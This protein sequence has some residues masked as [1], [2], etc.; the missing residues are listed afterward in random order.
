MLNIVL[1]PRLLDCSIDNQ[2]LQTTKSVR[3]QSE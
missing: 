1:N 2:H 3:Q